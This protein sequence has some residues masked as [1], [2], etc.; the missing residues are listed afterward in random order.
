MSKLL[1]DESPLV[2]QPTLAKAIGL[3]EAI[4]L[5]QINYWMNT[6]GSGKVI[7]GERWIYNTV[8]EWQEQFPFWSEATITRTLENLEGAQLIKTGNYNKSSMDRT[9]WYSINFAVVELLDALIT[10]EQDLKN[11]F[12]QND[13][14][15]L[16]NL[17]ECN[18]AECEDIPET[19]KDSTKTTTAANGNIFSQYENLGLLINPTIAEQLKEAE[20]EY[21]P[22]WIKE[23]FGRAA[24]ANIRKWSYIRGILE[25]WKTAGQMDYPTKKEEFVRPSAPAVNTA[26]KWVST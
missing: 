21:P 6:K 13:K 17:Q 10:Q 16:G 3:N 5:Q 26:P 1:F 11:A 20:Q 12:C 18:L 4:V 25:N 19:T 9:K 7:K 15:E 23:A 14:M 22:D 8:K 24:A 2:V